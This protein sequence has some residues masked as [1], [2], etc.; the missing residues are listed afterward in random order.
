MGLKMEFAEPQSL[1]IWPE[2]LHALNVFYRQRTQW[3][4]GMAGVIGLRNESLEF[5]L[6]LEGVP[7]EEWPDVVDGVQLMESETMRSW[8]EKCPR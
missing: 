2:N 1:G 5:A 7:A 4:V 3:N 8:R 6:R